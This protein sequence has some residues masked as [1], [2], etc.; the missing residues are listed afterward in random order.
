MYLLQQVATRYLTLQ[1]RS[2]G[3]IARYHKIKI[4]SVNEINHLKCPT[5]EKLNIC[6]SK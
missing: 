3:A 5:Y 6:D 4:G 2:Q 1:W